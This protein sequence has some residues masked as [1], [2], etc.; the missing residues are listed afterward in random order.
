MW[1]ERSPRDHLMSVQL[2]FFRRGN[3]VKRGHMIAQGHTV[4]QA[5]NWINTPILSLVSTLREGTVEEGPTPRW[6]PALTWSWSYHLHL[7]VVEPE[8]RKR[9]CLDPL[10]FG[11]SMSTYGWVLFTLKYHL[12]HYEFKDFT[13]GSVTSFVYTFPVG[14]IYLHSKATGVT[15]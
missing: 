15:L 5:L 14:E 2:L 7:Q 6:S 4:S 12:T 9:P 11:F 10:I 13:L 3:W 8:G 1:N